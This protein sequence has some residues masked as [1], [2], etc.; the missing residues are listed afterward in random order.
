MN[1][2]M[3]SGRSD[4]IVVVTS[5]QRQKR[6]TSE[7]KVVIVKQTNEPGSTVFWLPEST[8]LRMLSCFNGVRPTLRDPL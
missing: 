2:T 8:E 4:Q 6:M 1:M 7:Q 5:V 3:S